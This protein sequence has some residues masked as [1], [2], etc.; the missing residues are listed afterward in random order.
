MG[1]VERA[2]HGW[3]PVNGMACAPVGPHAHALTQLYDCEI[4][5]IITVPEAY[6]L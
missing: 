2:C 3:R 1:L 6:N 5:E 4:P